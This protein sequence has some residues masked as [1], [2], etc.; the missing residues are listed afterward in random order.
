M[1][2]DDRTKIRF[3]KLVEEKK[4]VEEEIAGMRFYTTA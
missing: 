1:S 2:F 4:I 3:N